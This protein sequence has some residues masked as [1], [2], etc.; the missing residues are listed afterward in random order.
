MK[1]KEIAVCLFATHDYAFSVATTCFGLLE[2]NS[3]NDFKFFIM[4]DGI[5]DKDQEILK[6]ILK[7]IDFIKFDSDFFHKISQESLRERYSESKISELLKNRQSYFIG[8]VYS[9]ALLE[10]YEK[11]LYLDTDLLIRG[12][13]QSVFE[14]QG[15]SWR[16]ATAKAYQKLGKAINQLEFKDI[17]KNFSAPNAGLMF[18]TSDIP[19]K[20]MLA[21]CFWV[22]QE[23]HELLRNDI[24]EAVISWSTYKFNVPKNELDY[25]FNQWLYHA[26]D[27][28]VV[29]HAIGKI[30]FWTANF[31][32]AIF[33][34][35]NDYYQKWLNLGGTQCNAEVEDVKYLSS[36]TGAG[37]LARC[38]ENIIFWEKVYI[39]MGARIPE[40]L[41]RSGPMAKTYS[42]LFIKGV[43]K[44][45]HYEISMATPGKSNS[46]KIHF[47]IKDKNAFKHECFLQFSI[48]L[49][50][51]RFEILQRKD[52]FV[53]S[54]KR[55]YLIDE[56]SYGL[57][58]L[59]NI[60]SKAGIDFNEI[61]SVLVA[62]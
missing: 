59:I 5:V 31:R 51:T 50:S 46:A 30:K 24:D 48:A 26:D 52:M 15:V 17:N 37:E 7:N 45:I 58:E 25:K 60:F 38:C 28:T 33:S 22:F 39:A 55:A 12:S 61:E 9:L 6:S 21:E 47:F 14:L 20:E 16:N 43:S 56:I 8:K 1:S 2:H 13:L 18:F 49:E 19:Y 62:H 32:K 29:C 34:E 54:S 35:W 23:Y 36:A 11:V 4:H 40:N 10:R 53:V 3:K 44:K 27:Q 57:Q 41:Y 42:Q